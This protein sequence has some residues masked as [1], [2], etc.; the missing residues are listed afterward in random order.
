MNPEPLNYNELGFLV[1]SPV[2]ILASSRQKKVTLKIN[3]TTSSYEKSKKIFEAW[4]QEEQ[5]QDHGSRELKDIIKGAFMLFVTV[6]NKW[7]EINGFTATLDDKKKALIFSF[8]L[9]GNHESMV[10][11]DNEIHE[12]NF[13]SEW[14]CVKIVL[15]NYAK[16][17][18]YNFLKNLIIENVCIKTDVKGV[19]DL[20]LH[21]NEGGLNNSIPFTPFGPIPHVGNYLR[22]KNPLI[23]QKNL[24]KLKLNFEWCG[25]P[26]EKNGFIDYYA[27]YH[28]KINN[29]SFKAVINQ[30][31]KL[32]LGHKLQEIELFESNATTNRLERSKSIKVKLEKLEFNDTINLSKELGNDSS[33]PLYIILESPE[34][35]FGHQIF[36]TK[37]A[38]AAMFNARI[39]KRKSIDL[40]KQPYTPILECLSINYTNYVKEPV[41]SKQKYHQSDIKF[42]H[43]NLFGNIQVFPNSTQTTCFLLPQIKYNRHL[44]IGVNNLQ[45]TDFGSTEVNLSS[46]IYAITSRINKPE[47]KWKY[48]NNNRWIS[49]K[50]LYMHG[51][52][53]NKPQL[54]L[55]ELSIGSDFIIDDTLDNYI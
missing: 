29:S 4:S 44:L 28:A 26:Q 8:G 40:P 23:L 34:I 42:I 16:I 37:Y 55:D 43:F 11:L 7:R 6:E 2:L 48:L 51:P 52:A 33:R 41:K 24:T 3:F 18:P 10:P 50:P 14:P 9:L 39:F 54:A 35:A 32:E 25:L 12:G 53:N 47:L 17:Y 5:T 1:S 45:A 27:A 30:T 49:I 22:I 13:E 38:E 46:V 21:N 20:K 36:S 19:T 31:A 15:N